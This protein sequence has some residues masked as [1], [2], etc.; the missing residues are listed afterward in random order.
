[1]GK[2]RFPEQA[3]GEMA[4]GLGVATLLPKLRERMRER[5]AAGADPEAWVCGELLE[6]LLACLGWASDERRW[7]REDDLRQTPGTKGPDYTLWD[8]AERWMYLEVRRF[9]APLTKATQAVY[10]L[11]RYAWS[12][13]LR[14]CVLTNFDEWRVY[15]GGATPGERD[16]IDH[17]LLAAW[18]LED[19][20]AEA[21]L[22]TWLGVSSQP[23]PPADSLARF[24]A[25]WMKEWRLALARQWNAAFPQVPAQMLDERG[26]HLLLAMLVA[27]RLEDIGI[28]RYGAMLAQVK[29]KGWPGLVETLARLPARL[30]AEPGGWT[31]EWEL[32]NDFAA[33]LTASLYY[34][35]CPVEFSALRPGALEQAWEY[36]LGER[37]RHTAKGL[38]L[39]TRVEIAAVGGLAEWPAHARDHAARQVLQPLVFHGQRDPAAE[40]PPLCDPVSGSGALLGAGYRA[41]LHFQ[42]G[43]WLAARARD[44]D[45][46]KARLIR[47]ADGM[48]RL[49][50]AERLR[51]LRQ[52]IFG[53]DADGLAV[54][55]TRAALLMVLVEDWVASDTFSPD[56]FPAENIR[57]ADV[58]GTLHPGKE[59][60]RAIEQ[61]SLLE[62][63][64]AY[65]VQTDWRYLFQR[66]QGFACILT[67][68]P[69]WSLAPLYADAAEKAGIPLD[70]P[71]YA[72]W[73]AQVMDMLRPDGRL[74]L[75]ARAEIYRRQD[76]GKFRRRLAKKVM[77]EALQT[78]PADH[79]ADHLLLL[80]VNREPEDAHL[81]LCTTP[82]QAER[83][84]DWQSATG[85][86]IAQ[87]ELARRKNWGKLAEGK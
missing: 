50:F 32:S 2:P 4:P 84:A 86:W 3:L 21:Q 59:E 52:G 42:R 25:D 85:V 71:A 31:E 29:K 80:A 11:R 1:M 75:L 35:R 53:A 27:R 24:L 38:L 60:P 77:L 83:Q 62:P 58:L 13:G 17:G 26:F 79:G 72:L 65:A 23:P 49:T 36:A 45:A 82:T 10:Q 74:G 73:I 16:K 61:F 22:A 55:A 43:L 30:G 9:D 47:G 51:L 12:A 18:R 57:H 37:L 44:P 19:D 48:F 67:A 64:A 8:G 68:P 78:I 70:G 66:P 33:R 39:E 34:P 41:L 40:P 5:S 63:V 87:K 56:P 6:P 46:E 54:A 20:A 7:L 15:D 28:H 76:L 14:W 81:V 69:A